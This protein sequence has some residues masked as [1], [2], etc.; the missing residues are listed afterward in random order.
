MTFTVR[1]AEP[2]DRSAVIALAPRLEAFGI[3]GNVQPNE[4]ADAEAAA[5]R[6]AFDQMPNGAALLVAV[7]TAEQVLGSVFVETKVDYFTQRSHGHVG[8]LTVAQEA[9]GRGIGR[10]LLAAA[11]EWALTMG[12]DRLT[13][14]VFEK[15]SRA[16][17]LYER[18]DYA[19]D[20]VRYR[21]DLPN[22][23]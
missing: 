4:L 9:E 5:L 17:A 23:G 12:F 19:P 15:N 10:A 18:A 16:R 1:P 20:L 7:D 14:F 3:P 13:L 6:Q 2:R 8:I 11:D 22:K 21:K